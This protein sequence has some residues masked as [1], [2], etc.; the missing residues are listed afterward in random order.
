[1]RGKLVL[2]GAVV[3]LVAAG[4]AALLLFRR[5]QEPPKPGGA[6]DTKTAAIGAEI[7]L[8]GTIRAQSVVAVPAPAG[9]TL[10]ELLVEI[11]ERVFEGQLLGRI[12]NTGLEVEHQQAAA[13]VAS[14]QERVD[15]LQSEMINARLEASRA[16]ADANRAQLEF[17]R[18]ERDFRRQELLF[19]EGAT[20]RK[21]FESAQAEYESRKNDFDTLSRVAQLAEERLS[22]IVSR[23]DTMRKLLEE[24]N[25]ALE[26]ARQ[27]AATEIRSPADGLVIARP[28]EVGEE[29]AAAAEVLQIAVNLNALEAVVEPEPPVLAR[30]RPGQEALIQTAELPDAIPGKVKQ[31]EGTRVIVEF[32]SPDPSLLPGATAQVRI[33]LT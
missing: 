11:G 5:A 1:M 23:L 6:K 2:T 13:E 21:V 14:T 19:K 7:S 4:A 16:R 12:E 33:K 32:T 29:V 18:A 15:Q 31:I 30:V 24:R 17:N 27:A 9:G 3:V 20:P 28:R 22:G 25:A 8:P 26:E 10:Q